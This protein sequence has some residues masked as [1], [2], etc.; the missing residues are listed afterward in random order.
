LSGFLFLFFL[1]VSPCSSLTRLLVTLLGREMMALREA[2]SR[3][4]PLMACAATRSRP[5][6][7][8]DQKRVCW[9]IGEEKDRTG[10]AKDLIFQFP[11]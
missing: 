3:G 11:I 10:R 4:S 6:F 8:L 7:P 2:C 1:F 9:R 5:C